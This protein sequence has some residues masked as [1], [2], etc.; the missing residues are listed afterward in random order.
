MWRIQK[1]P[2]P[3]KKRQDPAQWTDWMWCVRSRWSSEPLPISITDNMIPFARQ[4]TQ[5]TSEENPEFLFSYSLYLLLSLFFSR[6]CW[7]ERNRNSQPRAGNCTPVLYSWVY[8][9]RQVQ[10]ILQS[11]KNYFFPSCSCHLVSPFRVVLVEQSGIFPVVLS[12]SRA[13]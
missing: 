9:Y 13:R 2:E 10:L 3:T 11:R 4:Q 7:L 6:S 12:N 1:K 8:R 5:G